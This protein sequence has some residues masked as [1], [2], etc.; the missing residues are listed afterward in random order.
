MLGR[1]AGHSLPTK[2]AG[3]ACGLDRAAII[4][5]EVAF[6]LRRGATPR[7]AA[8]GVDTGA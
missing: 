4:R 6:R 8:M 5:A 1:S 3:A 2:S 7:P